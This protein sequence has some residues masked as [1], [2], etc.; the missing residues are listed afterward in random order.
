MKTITT[1]K[2]TNIII[3]VL[4]KTIVVSKSYYKRACVYGTVE[5]TELRGAMMDNPEFK[6][7][8]KTSDKKTY[9][10]LSLEKMAEYIRTQ[11]NSE[12]LLAELEKVEAIAKD[13][14]YYNNS[15]SHL[16]VF[17]QV[18]DCSLVF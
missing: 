12:A 18:W 11:E 8:F 13:S 5:Y 17:N 4:D 6:I 10:G 2:K 14:L 15:K 9:G 7:E 1:T 16:A 3:N